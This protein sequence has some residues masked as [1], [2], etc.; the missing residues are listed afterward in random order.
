M[1]TRIKNADSYRDGGIARG[2]N[3]DSAPLIPSIG[4]PDAQDIKRGFVFFELI[5]VLILIT[6]L[7]I[8]VIPSFQHLVNHQYT[9]MV[10]KKMLQ[11]LHLSQSS[12]TT[13]NQVIMFCGTQDRKTCSND[14]SKGQIIMTANAQQI[15][16]D[17][18]GLRAGDRL[19]WKS[20]LGYNDGLKFA[21]SG[22]TLGQRGSFY[23]C[24]RVHPERYGLIITIIDSGRARVITDPQQLKEA[25]LGS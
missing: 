16:Y 18:P 10:E 24:P 13:R 17:Y 5:L 1:G 9:Q 12:A 2:E 6:I 23:Y 14:W 21:P 25:C 19:W 15:I 20:S 7:T 4:F 8:I 3:R 22:F 11:A